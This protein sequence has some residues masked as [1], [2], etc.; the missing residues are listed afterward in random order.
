MLFVGAGVSANLGLPDWNAL[1]GRIAEELG[2]DPKIF[3]T[4]GTPWR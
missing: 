3:A 4:Y 1:I 2:Y